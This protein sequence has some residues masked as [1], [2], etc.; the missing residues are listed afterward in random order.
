VPL[1]SP[2]PAPVAPAAARADRE[3]LSFVEELLWAASRRESPPP[4]LFD[5]P[6]CLSLV[7]R[8]RNRLQRG[9]LDAALAAIVRRHA[10]LRSAF[11]ERNG[12]AVRAIASPSSTILSTVD[13]RGLTDDLRAAPLAALLERH[14]TQPF[15]LARGPLLR[16][17]LVALA[18]EEHVLAITV[19]HIA[20]DTWSKRVLVLEL[21]E[22]YA[23]YAAGRPGR[24]P[25]LEAEYDDYIRW[26]HS[27]VTGERGVALLAFWRATL[28]APEELALPIAP[29][30]EAPGSMRAGTCW[31]TIGAEDTWHMRAFSQ[32]Q[33]LTLATTLLTLLKLFLHR[34]TGS[35]SVTVG[36][37]LSDRRRHE[38]EAL[39][40]FFSNVVVV[41]TDFEEC[42]TFTALL[43]RVH[44]ILTEAYSHQDLPYGY[45]APLLGGDR[46]LYRV[47]YNFIPD[48]PASTIE[49]DGLDVERLRFS[50]RPRSLADLSLNVH[51]A[52]GT[53]SCRFVYRRALLSD[54]LV[55][56]F[57]R[58]FQALAGQVV[59]APEQPL[60]AFVLES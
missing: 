46:S 38:F 20:F 28:R 60:R 45:W 39:I 29:S 50:A 16:A 23:A 31:F 58:Q 54:G 26:Q 1:T 2:I 37:P 21:K 59:R 32:R 12:R 47:V 55:R 53:L 51:C 7:V 17:T 3:A 13:L 9:A 22:L 15:D 25:E 30:D 41:R 19:H 6:P 48:G 42:E 34:L 49:L 10:P 35:A 5:C 56:Q 27:N 36:L 40:G 4:A 14:S 24:V 44:R 52:A 33:R 57:A 18:D 43:R 8:L 11:P